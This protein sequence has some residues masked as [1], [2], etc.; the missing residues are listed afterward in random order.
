L[1]TF[2]HHPA[3][4]FLVRNGV[5]DQRVKEDVNTVISASLIYK[6]LNMLIL[7]WGEKVI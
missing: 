2:Y 6:K 5:G 3:I 1:L 7:K 4:L